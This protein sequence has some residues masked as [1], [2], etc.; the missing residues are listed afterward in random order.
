MLNL[1]TVQQ[2]NDD[3]NL[4]NIIYKSGAIL[5]KKLFFLIAPV[6]VFFFVF[7]FVFCLSKVKK[8]F[9]SKPDYQTYSEYQN[10][11]LNKFSSRII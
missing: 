3:R 6:C 2:L 10:F 5:L 7:F 1:I 9:D 11:K 8:M 4:V